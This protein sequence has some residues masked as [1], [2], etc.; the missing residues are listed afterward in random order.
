MACNWREIARYEEHARTPNKE[1]SR[2]TM[3]AKDYQIIVIDTFAKLG[4][5]NELMAYIR[6]VGLPIYSL[7]EGLLYIDEDERTIQSNTVQPCIDS[8]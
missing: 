1:F 7:K 6:K 3:Q 4:S 2:M 8:T 5:V